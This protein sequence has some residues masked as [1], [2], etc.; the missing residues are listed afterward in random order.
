M[1]NL[2]FNFLSVFMK[3]SLVEAASSVVASVEFLVKLGSG[4]LSVLQP[5][6]SASPSSS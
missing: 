1:L 5:S 2:G 3:S 4:C 6:I